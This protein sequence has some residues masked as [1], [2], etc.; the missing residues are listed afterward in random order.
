MPKKRLPEDIE[1]V[2]L[3]LRLPVNLKAQLEDSARRNRRS[4]N[5]EAQLWLEAQVKALGLLPESA[6]PSSPSTLP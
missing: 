2:P 6:P 3:S 5:Q 4:V 1:L